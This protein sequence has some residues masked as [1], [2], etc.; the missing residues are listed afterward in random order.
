MKEV[1]TIGDCDALVNRV[2]AAA[3]AV[4][5]VA[6]AGEVLRGGQHAV[7]ISEMAGWSL[8]PVDGRLHQDDELRVLTEA[9]VG[10]TPPV[11]LRSGDARR[12]DP[13]GS[14]GAG[15]GRG[16]VLDLTNQSR[17]ARSAQ[18]D[19]VGEYGGPVHVAV[20][21][22]RV[23]AVQ[24][25]DVQAGSQCRSLEAV[26]H[27]GPG[28]GG[29]LARRGSPAGPVSYTHLTLPTIYSV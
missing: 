8:E 18:A 26:D 9:L 20:P 10:A 12:E 16:D 14:A 27:V 23:D 21:V 5:R 11:V 1:G 6:V 3:S 4:R 24:Q 25:R 19:V 28:R 2:V 15:L 29:V 13:L 7:A 17:V 22:H